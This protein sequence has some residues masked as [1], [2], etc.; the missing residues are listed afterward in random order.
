VTSTSSTSKQTWKNNSNVN[1]I[2]PKTQSSPV[3]IE[4]E[5]EKEKEREY[6]G[7]G[8]GDRGD[9][10]GDQNNDRLSK[11][12]NS[13]YEINLKLDRILNHLKIN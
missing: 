13:I 4:K 5:K 7:D 2:V 11:I 6:D 1:I 8:N 9:K 12:E 10:G 3:L